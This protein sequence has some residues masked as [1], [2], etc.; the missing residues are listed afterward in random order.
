[1]ARSARDYR[2]P[3]KPIWCA[4]CGDFAVLAC[5]QEA[6]ARLEWDPRDVAL[7]SGIGCSGR[8]PHFLHSNGFHTLHGRAL[9]VATG[10]HLANQD[11]HVIAVGGD[12]DGF[13]IGLG[14]FLH[15]CHRNVRLTYVVMDNEV[16]GQTK[17]HA[18]PTLESHRLNPIALALAAGCTFVARGYSA[19]TQELVRLLMQALTHDGFA[20]VDV[21]SPCT[22]FHDTYEDLKRRVAALP[23]NHDPTDVAGAWK[24]SES[25]DPL[26][27]GLYH[28]RTGGQADRGLPS[29]RPSGLAGL[30]RTLGLMG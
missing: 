7:V 17:G 13:S 24:L 22:T 18:S 30:A 19:R 10:A 26:Y 14:H 4:G 15:A 9:P 28:R 25:A 20:F 27:L 2:G 11:L 12:G 29:T 16:Y 6:L 23:A 3:L 1:M 21:I 5:L 8:F